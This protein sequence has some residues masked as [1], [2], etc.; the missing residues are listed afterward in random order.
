MTLGPYVPLGSR[1]SM[2]VAHFVTRV[3]G[4]AATSS[5]ISLT[6]PSNASA[7]LFLRTPERQYTISERRLEYIVQLHVFQSALSIQ[8]GTPSFASSHSGSSFLCQCH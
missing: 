6:I 1:R 4:G 5:S 3:S 8:S 2:A 7:L